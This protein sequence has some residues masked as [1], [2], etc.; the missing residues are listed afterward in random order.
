[1]ASPTHT[2]R[3]ADPVECPASARILAIDYGRRQL[4][5][6]VSDELGVT[7]QTLPVMSRVNRRTDTQLLR[8]LV[9]EKNVRMIIVGSPVHLSGRISEMSEEA[10]KFAERLAKELRLPVELRDER[11]TSWDA[12]Q[13]SEELGLKKHGAIDSVA[14]AILLRE[15][16][17]EAHPPRGSKPTVRQR[18]EN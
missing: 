14:A 9:K 2:R 7:A 4:G 13:M 6:A 15:Y 3:T 11:L 5:L 10:K 12:E 16:L 8:K 18:C 17:N 1:M